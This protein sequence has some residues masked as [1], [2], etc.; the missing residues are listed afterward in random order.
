MHTKK[1]SEITV[2]KLNKTLSNTIK[3]NFFEI[4]KIII[5]TLLSIG[6]FEICFFLKIS[7]DNKK[8]TFFYI[9]TITL[10]IFIYI[11]LKMFVKKINIINNKYYYIFTLNLY[12]FIKNYCII[13][14]ALILQYFLIFTLKLPTN[15]ENQ[16]AIDRNWDILGIVISPAIIEELCFRGILFIIIFGCTSYLF[17]KNNKENDW[18]GE[19]AFIFVSTT[20]FGFGH[21]IVNS[22]FQN[23]SVYLISGFIFSL[24]YI[25]TKNIMYPIILHAIGNTITL[26]GINHEE[27][28]KLLFVVFL[29]I[30]FLI[31]IVVIG[32]K[33]ALKN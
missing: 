14:L 27:E 2:K 8:N 25:I 21:V 5:L 22:D 16:K 20:L 28:M 17:N 30:L 10:S 24:V 31:F 23:V 13:I 33:K 18:F 9:V 1:E 26:L 3:N 15:T 32:V 11:L 4:H 19:I 29:L 6:V 12:N 7:G